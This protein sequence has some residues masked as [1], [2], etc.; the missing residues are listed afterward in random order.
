[1]DTRLEEYILKI[2]E[3][4]NVTHA[5][6]QLFITQSAL[7][8][9]LL[10]LEQELGII[11]FERTRNEM[12]LTDAGR[13]YCN[14]A[15][16]LID[17]K[18]EAYNI[19]NDMSGNIAGT[20]RV[21]LTR[22]RGIDMFIQVFPK[23]YELY[24]L[25]RI[26]PFELSASDQHNLLLKGDLD[27][28]FVPL[29]KKD[30]LAVIEY[31]PFFS[32]SLLLAMPKGR[33][34]AKARENSPNQPFASMELSDFIQL[35]EEPFV[36]ISKASSLRTVIDPIFKSADFEPRLLFETTSN[37]TLRNMAAHNLACSILPHNY[38]LDRRHVAYFYLPGNPH[39]DM[40]VMYR[41]GQYLTNAARTFITLAQD[42]FYEHLA[43]LE[44]DSAQTEEQ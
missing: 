4:G 30:R 32:E 37:R 36:L 38:A 27:L 10:K 8:Q 12:K 6:A 35:K 39:W 44:R 7:T 14:Y 2:A 3:T 29:A 33:P 13:I 24:P 9:Q 34:F 19:L 40:N 28:G 26:I 17:T 5:A 11:L 18:R 15:R 25:T 16:R 23:F 31:V 42:Y 20:L 22:E 21:G 1:M 43:L 41:K